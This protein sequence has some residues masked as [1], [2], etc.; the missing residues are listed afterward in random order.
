MHVHQIACVHVKF[1]RFEILL[2]NLVDLCN[3][4]FACQP[5]F[6]K[7]EAAGNAE[8]RCRGTGRRGWTGEGACPYASALSLH[9]TDA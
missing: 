9:G 1:N 3:Q 7:H 5:S 8:R 2:L 6:T 4:T